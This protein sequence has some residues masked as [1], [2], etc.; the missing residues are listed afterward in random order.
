M[1]FGRRK[2]TRWLNGIAEG[3]RTKVNCVSEMV[4]MSVWT[5]AVVGD[6]G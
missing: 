1:L 4:M 5:V 2:M 6:G 3:G